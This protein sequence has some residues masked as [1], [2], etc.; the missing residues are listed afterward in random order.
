M[1]ELRASLSYIVSLRTT[2]SQTKRIL[3][4]LYIV[5]YTANVSMHIH[6]LHIKPM[7]QGE[8]EQV[9][10]FRACNDGVGLEREVIKKPAELSY[11]HD[12]RILV[13]QTLFQFP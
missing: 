1:E 10:L 6:V 12:G 3:Y 7:I 4:I 11:L 5:S 8:Y 9:V 2:L 13:C